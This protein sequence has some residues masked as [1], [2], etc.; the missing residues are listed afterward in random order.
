M[1]NKGREICKSASRYE[2][3]Q[4]RKDQLYRK[5]GSQPEAQ[6]CIVVDVWQHQ[7]QW[8]DH[9]QGPA[10]A[11]HAEQWYCP[12][13]ELII[14]YRKEAEKRSAMGVGGHPWF[15]ITNWCQGQGKS[16]CGKKGPDTAEASRRASAWVTS[17]EDPTS[18]KRLSFEAPEITG[19]NLLGKNRNQYE[20][21]QGKIIEQHLDWM[22]HYEA[23]SVRWII[24]G[25]EPRLGVTFIKDNHTCTGMYSCRHIWVWVTRQKKKAHIKRL[26]VHLWGPHDGNIRDSER[27]DNMWLQ[28][29]RTTLGLQIQQTNEPIVWFLDK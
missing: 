11:S 27:D 25:R 7:G 24:T 21:H 6:T 1:R 29:R 8:L 2:L 3:V 17:R 10:H 22:I 5:R 9:Y 23:I 14:S 19:D 26:Y 15:T 18:S 20:Q 13:N 16:E 4:R 28:S 12:R